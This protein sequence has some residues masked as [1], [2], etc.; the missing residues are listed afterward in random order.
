MAC[1]PHASVVLCFSIKV[2]AVERSGI[3]L[4]PED[5]ESGIIICK[6]PYSLPALSPSEVLDSRL[7]LQLL[8]LG[9]MG[10]IIARDEI[11]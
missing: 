10:C 5:P 7:T 4:R 2:D 3:S 11:R 8:R 1:R 9:F 6:E